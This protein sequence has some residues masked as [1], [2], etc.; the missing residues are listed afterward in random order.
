MQF[1]AIQFNPSQ[2]KPRE[3]NWIQINSIQSNSMQ[4]D[5]NRFNFNWFN[6]NPFPIQFITRQLQ[7]IPVFSIQFNS[8]QA[9][10]NQ[11]HSSQIIAWNTNQFRSST[12]Q[13]Q[14]I[15]IRYNELDFDS[16]YPSNTTQFN[17]IQCYL[18]KS[19][20]FD[21]SQAKARHFKSH[22]IVLVQSHP[23]RFNPIQ[24]RPTRCVSSQRNLRQFLYN[25]KHHFNMFR[26]SSLRSKPLQTN[27]SNPVQGIPTRFN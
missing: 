4:L 8:I 18:F 2:W 9:S 1:N 15:S 26:F 20:H 3:V 13:Y 24:S 16:N 14:S 17:S 7:L 25:S 22:Q 5:T 21:W 12:I 6:F 10:P 27:P 19:L 23:I 11:R